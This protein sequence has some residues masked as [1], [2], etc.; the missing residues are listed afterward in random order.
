[1]SLNFT[2]HSNKRKEIYVL[3]SDKWNAWVL[4][5]EI[6]TRKYQCKNYKI[7]IYF[8][9]NRPKFC[10]L[11]FLLLFR[12]ITKKSDRRFGVLTFKLFMDRSLRI[13]TCKLAYN[14]CMQWQRRPFIAIRLYCSTCMS[15]TT[16]I[17]W[18]VPGIN[19]WFFVCAKDINK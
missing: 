11:I 7:K 1:M 18:S 3:Y 8:F 2:T 15:F 9:Y 6:S 17:W 5:E 16:P 14:V 13:S 4:K 19:F 10:H 12:N